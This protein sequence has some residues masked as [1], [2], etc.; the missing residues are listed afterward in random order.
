MIIMLCHSIKLANGE[1]NN[2]YVG[3]KRQNKG[4]VCHVAI[5]LACVLVSRA[6]RIFPRMRMCVRKWAGGGKE[7]YIWADLPGFPD[8]SSRS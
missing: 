8:S 4:N 3:I 1:N 5:L 7:K 2:N 6:S